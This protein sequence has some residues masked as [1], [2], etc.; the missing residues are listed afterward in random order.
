MDEPSRGSP[1]R[2]IGWGLFLASSWT[3]CIGAFLPLLLLR[4]WG[5]QGFVVFALPNVIGATTVGFLWTSER[6]RA[7]TERRRGL[8]AWFSVATLSYQA[9]FIAWMA[10]SIVTA[11]LGAAPEAPIGGEQW[12]A[13]LM[14]M[15]AF[16]LVVSGGRGR[17][18]AWILL[19]TIVSLG[20]Y[21]LWLR[22]GV[23]TGDAAVVGIAPPLDLWLLA[24]AIAMGFLVCPHL[25][26]TFHRV[27]QRDGTRLPWLVFAPAFTAML[28]ITV[29]GWRGV[30]GAFAAWWFIQVSFTAAAHAR[31]LRASTIRGVGLLIPVAVLL[32]AFAGR[33]GFGDE[34]IYLRFLGL[35]GAV[36][37]GIALLLWRGRS[38]IAILFFLAVAIPAFEVGFLG[39]E[40]DGATRWAWAP[41]IP[42][43]LLLGML[44]IPRRIEHSDTS[45]AVR[46]E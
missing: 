10:P 33:P 5:W 30:T 3:W 26:L 29:S 35:Y 8:L 28:F 38:G 7:F 44:A 15:A 24:P 13:W 43:A 31:E 11:T 36:F 39:S 27:L 23:G 45:P 6:S 22:H 20:S 9:F 12:M 46:A 1:L 40:G 2:S 25:D 37:P 34:A 14:A 18:R 16:A 19:G 32:G 17:D 41:L 4:D 21:A 42:I